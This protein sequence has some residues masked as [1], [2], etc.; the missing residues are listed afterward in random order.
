MVTIT[1]QKTLF[2]FNEIIKLS[3]T[4]VILFYLMEW[5]EESIF[6]YAS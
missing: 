5:V 4:W 1:R 3:D 2:N 6:Y